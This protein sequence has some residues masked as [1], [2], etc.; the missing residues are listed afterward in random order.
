MVKPLCLDERFAEI[1]LSGRCW[2]E[3]LRDQQL[4]EPPPTSAG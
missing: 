3:Q 2:S 4:A 1:R